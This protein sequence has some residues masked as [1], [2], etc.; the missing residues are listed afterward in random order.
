MPTVRLV[1][2]L[3]VIM[4]G[5]ERGWRIRLFLQHVTLLNKSCDFDRIYQCVGLL[6]FYVNANIISKT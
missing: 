3:G 1:G 5:D 4:I 2:A 6:D